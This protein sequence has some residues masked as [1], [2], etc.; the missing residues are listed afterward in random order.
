MTCEHEFIGPSTEAERREALART[1]ERVA[2]R[3]SPTGSEH[4]DLREIAARLRQDPPVDAG[5]YPYLSREDLPDEDDE[6]DE[7]EGG[8][9]TPTFTAERQVQFTDQDDL[10]RG[11]W[12]QG[13]R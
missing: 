11:I 8:Y 5:P 6:Q 2:G 9:E 7:D 1:C 3:L 10:G 4:N 12:G 13:L